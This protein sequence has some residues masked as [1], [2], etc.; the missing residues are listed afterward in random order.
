MLKVGLIALAI[1]TPSLSNAGELVKGATILEVASSN[2][3][4]DVFWVRFS[5]GT[6][7]CANA[8]VDFPASKSQSKES[9][10]QSFSIALS[11]AATGSKIRVHNYEDDNCQGANFISVYSN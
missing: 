10:N 3:N 4:Q 8:S 5:G 2:G 9:Y 6:G 1:L 7:P 11:A